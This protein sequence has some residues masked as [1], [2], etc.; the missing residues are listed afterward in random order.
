MTK[1][2]KMWQGH[3][4]Q[5]DMERRGICTYRFLLGLAEE[6]GDAYKDIDEVVEPVELAGLSRRIARF[7]PVG[8]IKG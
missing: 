1:A 2:R 8:N 7:V 6:A 4:L 5:Q 3:S